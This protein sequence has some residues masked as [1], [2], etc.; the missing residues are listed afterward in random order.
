VGL[1]F[2]LDLVELM[3]CQADMAEALAGWL[4]RAQAV[5]ASIG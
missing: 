1:K 2:L 3:V 5:S 4:S